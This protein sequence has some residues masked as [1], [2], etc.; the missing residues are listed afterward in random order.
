MSKPMPSPVARS[1]LKSFALA[2]QAKSVDASCGVWANESPLLG[3]VTLR[4]N[5]GDSAFVDAAS[6]ALG[7]DLPTRPCT[8]TTSGAG[9][10]LW[11]SPDEWMIVCDRD[12][13][14]A[15]LHGLDTALAGIRSQVVDN[16]GGHTEVLMQGR[17]A[18]DVLAHCTVYDRAAL[19]EGRVVGTTFGKSSIYLHRQGDGYCLLFRRSF[20]DYIWRYLVRAAQP[21]GLGI[22]RLETDAAGVKGTLP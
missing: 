8:L 15:L 17:N 13:L 5:S 12:R 20:A 19:M 10:I 9:K 3:Y 22:S 18:D 11:L 7:V 14:S 21:Y 2:A 16:S 6:R 1:P 4:G